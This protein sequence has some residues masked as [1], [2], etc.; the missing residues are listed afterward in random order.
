VNTITGVVYR[1]DPTI[2]AWELINEPRVPQDWNGNVLQSWIADVSAHI[3]SIDP[4][5]MVTTGVEV[6]GALHACLRLAALTRLQSQG[7]FG[8]STPEQ[9]GNNPYGGSEG[10]DFHR[11]HDIDT[12]DFTVAH[13]ACCASLGC[14]VRH[15]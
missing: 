4:A 6:R 13:G 15:G 3:K 14:A 11:N 12:I 9:Q 7:F 1:D 10:T 2:F 8:P 5:H